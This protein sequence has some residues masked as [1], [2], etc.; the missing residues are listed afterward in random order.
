MRDLTFEEVSH[1]YGAGGR[2]KSPSP[3]KHRPCRPKRPKC[4]GRGGSGSD[5]GGGRC[6]KGGSS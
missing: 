5:S 3:P 1:V 2:S 6:G 4:R